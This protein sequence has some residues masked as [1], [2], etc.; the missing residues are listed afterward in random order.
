MIT[1][2]D[3]GYYLTLP[4]GEINSV[5]FESSFVAAKINI[6]ATRSSNDGVGRTSLKKRKE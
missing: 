6:V 2:G 5:D 1:G 4:Q 3:A